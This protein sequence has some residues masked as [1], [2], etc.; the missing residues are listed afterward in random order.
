MHSHI[1]PL[2]ICLHC[3]QDKSDSPRLNNVSLNELIVA[4]NVITNQ[5]CSGFFFFL[6]YHINDQL[7]YQCSWFWKN[8]KITQSTH[9]T[10]PWFSHRKR[11]NIFLCSTAHFY[12]VILLA[13]NEKHRKG[14]DFSIWVKAFLSPLPF[15]SPWPYPSGNV[16]VIQKELYT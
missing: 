15:F 1:M 8:N 2:K 3:S 12:L 4:E 16:I 6:W 13:K 7:C 5:K 14:N 10:Q 11:K 9:Y